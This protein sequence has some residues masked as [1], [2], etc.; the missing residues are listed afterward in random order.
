[1]IWFNNPPPTIR[2]DSKSHIATLHTV[3]DPPVTPI[4]FILGSQAHDDKESERDDNS[5]STAESVTA[6]EDL[7]DDLL[8]DALQES[9]APSNDSGMSTRVG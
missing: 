6:G 4:I 5:S 8:S 3:R 7:V 1:M 2:S 9:S